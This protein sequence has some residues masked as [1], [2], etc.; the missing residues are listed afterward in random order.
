M[1]YMACMQVLGLA[2]CFALHDKYLPT[3]RRAAS[4]CQSADPKVHPQKGTR[5]GSPSP[6]L[7]VDHCNKVVVVAD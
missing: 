1:T 7:S 5:S 4:H 3:Y 6:C 2:L